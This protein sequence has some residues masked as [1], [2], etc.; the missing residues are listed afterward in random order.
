M[1]GQGLAGR[2]RAR[3]TQSRTIASNLHVG[4]A[5]VKSDASQLFW[6]GKARHGKAVGV[7]R[8]ENVT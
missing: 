6:R 1:H 8:L 4:S 2:D 3:F 7:E 5:S